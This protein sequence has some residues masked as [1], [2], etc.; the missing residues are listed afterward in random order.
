VCPALLNDLYSRT[1]YRLTLGKTIKDTNKNSPISQIN[2][3]L[4]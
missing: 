4:L 1:A 3:I 2:D